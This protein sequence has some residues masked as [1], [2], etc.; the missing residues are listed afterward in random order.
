MFLGK[1]L[2]IAK[3]L[4]IEKSLKEKPQIAF[5]VKYQK[6]GSCI[7]LINEE[8]WSLPSPIKMNFPCVHFATSSEVVMLFSLN[9]NFLFFGQY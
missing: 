9:F 1:I 7:S 8:T 3:T 5:I 6:T 4:G 2:Q